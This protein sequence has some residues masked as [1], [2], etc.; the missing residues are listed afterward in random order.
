MRLAKGWTIHSLPLYPQIT[1]SL[2][3]ELQ[4]P[5]LQPKGMLGFSTQ[6]ASE[7]PWDLFPAPS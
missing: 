2:V 3:G 5:A 7:P 4:K 6:G 1:T